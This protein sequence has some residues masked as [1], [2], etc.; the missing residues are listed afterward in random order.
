MAVILKK[1][2]DKVTDLVKIYTS[3]KKMMKSILKKRDS[4]S[5]SQSSHR[6]ASQ[7]PPEPLNVEVEAKQHS[8]RTY[9][10]TSDKEP[11]RRSECSDYH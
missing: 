5:R 7:M 2:K 6:R 8:R 3:H 11:L 9:E 4:K 1:K 10:E